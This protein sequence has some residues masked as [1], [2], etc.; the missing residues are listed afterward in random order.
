VLEGILADGTTVDLTDRSTWTVADPALLAPIE[1][2]P[3]IFPQP[4]FAAR[5]PGTTTLTAHY[6]DLTATA[7]LTIVARKLRRI[8]FSPFRTMLRGDIQQPGNIS[9]HFDN[10]DIDNDWEYNVPLV[11]SHPDIIEVTSVGN[12]DGTTNRQLNAR[13]SGRSVIRTELAGIKAEAEITVIP[14]VDH[15]LLFHKKSGDYVGAEIYLRAIGVADDSPVLKQLKRLGADQFVK[16]KLAQQGIN[17]NELLIQVVNLDNLVDWRTSDPELMKFNIVGE[18]WPPSAIMVQPGEAVVT[19][20]I[21]TLQASNTLTISHQIANFQLSFEDL[22][23]N[24]EGSYIL[25]LEIIDMNMRLA[26][27]DTTTGDRVDFSGSIIS[28]RSSAP[29]VVEITKRSSYETITPVAA[30]EATIQC[31]I[32][33]TDYVASERLVVVGKPAADEK[34]QSL[35]IRGA[36]IFRAYD[37]NKLSV[38]ATFASAVEEDITPSCTVEFEHP[39]LFQQERTASGELFLTGLHSGSTGVVA[40]CRGVESKSSPFDVISSLE[41]III[42]PA[43]QH[44]SRGK[45]YPLRYHRKFLGEATAA[46]GETKAVWHSSDPATVRIEGD[47]LIALESGRATLSVTMDDFSARMDLQVHN[48][49]PTTLRLQP[50]AMDLAIMQRVPFP[51][52]TGDYF[53]GSKQPFEPESCSWVTNHPGITVSKGGLANKPLRIYADEV[54]QYQLTISCDGASQALPI[55]VTEALLQSTTIVAEPAPLMAGHQ[56]RLKLMG[57]FSDGVVRDVTGNVAIWTSN[58]NWLLDSK[59]SVAMWPGKVTIIATPNFYTSSFSR[60]IPVQSTT[61][62]FEIKIP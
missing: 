12:L 8:E 25:P 59:R 57:R 6:A 1:S 47:R 13:R 15:L 54:G 51:A 9:L 35:R 37:R 3:G 29:T 58:P 19:A 16:E 5:L 52:I 21:G 20:S 43:L 60:K 27:D 39:E 55:T 31:R 61:A 14:S 62:E 45:R 2:A 42:D 56:V 11:S 33:G 46:T 32:Q 38:M 10:G 17:M 34:P 4:V 7:A 40:R 22:K 53:D 23:Q 49:G 50:S 48:N 18:I 44:L 24:D 28:C 26:A 41:S 30:G 36:D